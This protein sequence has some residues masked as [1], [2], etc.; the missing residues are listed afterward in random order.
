MVNPVTLY[1]IVLSHDSCNS[2]VVV[3]HVFCLTDLL[4]NHHV[5]SL[6]SIVT[7]CVVSWTFTAYYGI[8]VLISVANMSNILLQVSEKQTSTQK[9]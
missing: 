5:D 2:A 9:N 7:H 6:I 4:I 8:L 3:H 1:V